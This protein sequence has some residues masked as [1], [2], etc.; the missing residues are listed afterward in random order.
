MTREALIQRFLG[1]ETYRRTEFIV[2]RGG[3]DRYA[4]IAVD[5]LDRDPLFS[6]IT[7]VEVLALPDSCVYVRDPDADCGNRSAF[8]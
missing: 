8:S 3:G 7:H 4:V 5:A 6:P 2:L 1:R